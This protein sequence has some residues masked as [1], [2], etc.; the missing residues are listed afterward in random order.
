MPSVLKGLKNLPQKKS[1]VCDEP[2]IG[3]CA[4]ETERLAQLAASVV[5]AQIPR[6]AQAL[7]SLTVCHAKRFVVRQD[8]P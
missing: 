8:V 6:L 5:Q 4:T 2:E 1:A 3:T 7:E